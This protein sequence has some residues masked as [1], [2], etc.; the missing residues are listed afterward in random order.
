MWLTLPVA[1]E[2]MLADA[3]AVVDAMLAAGVDLGGVNLMT[4]DY[5]GARPGTL[6]MGEAVL[7]VADGLPPAAR[8]GLP[9]GRPRR[10]TRPRL[11]GKLGATPMIG[12]NDTLTDVFTPGRRQGA[13]RLRPRS[14]VWA[15]CRCGRPTGTPPAPADPTRRRVSNTCS[16]LAQAPLDFSRILDRGERPGAADR[17]GRPTDPR[18]GPVDD[19]ATSPYPVWTARR[20]LR[21]R[22]PCG[23]P[24]PRVRRQ[25]V[26]PGR[27]PGGAGG[28]RA[29]LAVAAGRARSCAS[30]RPPSTT[31]LPAGTYPD[32]DAATAYRR[33]DRVLRDGVAYEADWFAQGIDPAAPPTG[34]GPSPW[35]PLDRELSGSGSTTLRRWQGSTLLRAGRRRPYAFCP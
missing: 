11:W 29:R 22:R 10:S 18:P 35:R 6:P 3:V 30:D 16:G 23:P 7:R 1:P 21:A 15:A 4:M 25:V 33:G 31:T 5:G 17:P 13:G 19:P 9:A 14:T 34:D 20:R 8:R 32:W 12:V 26:D 27:R 28:Q 2:G 24:P